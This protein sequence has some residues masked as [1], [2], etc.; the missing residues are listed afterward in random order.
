MQ[1]G[2]GIGYLFA[3]RTDLTPNQPVAFGNIQDVSFDF[4]FEEKELHGQSQFPLAVARAKGK[5][6]G[7][8]KFA[9]FNGALFNNL[10]F[11]GTL[12]T[13]QTILQ[14]N[15][16]HAVPATPFTVTLAPPSSGTVVED[17]GVTYASSGIS[18]TRVT[19]APTLGQYSYAAGVYT[20]AAADTAASVNISYSYSVS[21]QSSTITYANQLMGAAPQFE[22]VW[23]NVYQGKA[24]YYKFNSC[25]STKFNMPMKLDDFTIPEFDFSAFADASGNLFSYSFAE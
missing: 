2:F 8:A 24:V 23:G 20:F 14:N 9:H 1:Y 17:L 11:G 12:A 13:G 19:S 3:N 10:F 16:N 4:S 7:K 25:I 5:I 22:I 21:A 18:F 6:Q 15:E